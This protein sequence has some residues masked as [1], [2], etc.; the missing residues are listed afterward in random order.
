VLTV[1]D[2]DAACTPIAA[3]LRRRGDIPV[4]E[5]DACIPSIE[6]PAEDWLRCYGQLQR[7]VAAPQ[8]AA[9]A[10]SHVTADRAVLDAQRHAPMPVAG[11]A[12][13]VYPKSYATLLRIAELDSAIDGLVRL[14]AVC[15]EGT[16]SLE[17]RDQLE[18]LE[19][20]L[21]RAQGLIVWAWTHP[22]VG[23]PWDVREPAGEIPGEILALLP[24]E[25]LLVHQTV[26]Q[27]HARL[28]A[29]ATLIDPVRREAGGTRPTWSGLFQAMG[30]EMG[31][32]P[33]ELLEAQSLEAV[34]VNAQ[35]QAHRMQPAEGKA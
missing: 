26:A 33:R 16:A 23:L 19:E 15:L 13:A 8:A 5:I 17:A 30:F 11:T 25:I 32:A 21:A 1:A 12:L 20:A 9:A 28:Q 31:V 10:Q 4:A 18:P 34:L 27:Q 35:L 7:W 3:M 6:A 29:L 24:E 2:L 22:G 14:L